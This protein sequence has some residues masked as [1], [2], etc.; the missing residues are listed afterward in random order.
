MTVGPF[1][2]SP[3]AFVRVRVRL[4]HGNAE[5]SQFFV[6]AAYFCFCSGDRSLGGQPGSWGAGWQVSAESVRRERL[7]VRPF[8][9]VLGDQQHF[10]ARAALLLALLALLGGQF[11]PRAGR[12]K[13][14]WRVVPRFCERRIA[15]RLYEINKGGGGGAVAKISRG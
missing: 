8:A 10:F 7:G 3:F 6:R 2:E 1:S 13:S 15:L 5:I 9:Y 14:G 11:E 4:V 12:G